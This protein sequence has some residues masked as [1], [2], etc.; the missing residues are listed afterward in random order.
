MG[1]T[2]FFENALPFVTKASRYLGN[3]INAT[4]KDLS[5]VDL[6]FALAFPDAYEVGMSH[7][8]FHILYHI[9]NSHDHIA[10][11]RVFAPWPDM[12][13]VMRQQ[14]F[15][16]STLESHIPLRAYDIIGFS[17]EYELSY[18]TILKMFS[19]SG[20][21]FL[22]HDRDESFP[23]MIAGGPSTFNPEPVADFF[24]AIVIGEGEEVICEV[25][26]TFLTW[27][28]IQAPKKELLNMLSE[29][30]GIYVPSLFEIAYDEDGTLHEI[31][32]LK[33]GYK[34]VYKRVI[35]GF[36]DVPFCISPI[37]PYM[38]IIHDRV[39]IEIARGCT[40]GCRF[41]MAGMI[42]RP[43][44]E[45]NIPKIRNLAKKIL[46]N[47]GYEELSLASLSTGDFSNIHTLLK[48][49]MED[50]RHNR[51]AVSF[52][53]L[54]VETLTR[55]LMEEIKQV[56]KTGF[57][58][59]PEAGTQRLRDVINK[60]ITDGEILKTASQI[61]SAGWNL[62]KLYFM[63]GLPTETWDDIEGIIHL[64]RKMTLIDHKKQLNVSVSTFVPKPHTPFQWEMQAPSETIQEKQ[65]FLQERIKKRNIRFKWHN[66]HLSVLEGIFSRGDRKLSDVLIKAHEA[67]AGFEA[68]TDY[69]RPEVWDQAF[70][71]CKIDKNFYLR[72]RNIDECLPW[73]HISCGI[74]TE[75]FKNELERALRVE[76]TP[77]CRTHGCA[78]CG[79]CNGEDKK[80][81]LNRENIFTEEKP[82]SL[83]DH[84]SGGPSLR[85][86]I[87]FTKTGP[88]RFLSHLELSSSLA[89]SMRRARL[90]LK[91]SNGFH[92]MP[93]II[94]Y[95]AL[96]VGMESLGHF[97]DVELT[98]RIDISELASI[99]NCYLP[100]GLKVILVKENFLKNRNLSDD[101]KKYIISFPK[102]PLYDYPDFEK[103]KNFIE[104]FNVRK[105]FIMHTTKRQESLHVDLKQLVNK[106]TLIECNTI[107]IELNRTHKKVPKLTEI[108]AHILQLGEKE[109]K[110]LRITRLGN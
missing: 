51:I 5:K 3:E 8:G 52:P 70:K 99:I 20:I 102:K 10:C 27:K 48:L 62:I 14:N 63:I 91:Y 61:F 50:H 25:C 9:L 32:P 59:A 13:S 110:A 11:E 75:F 68:W 56:R 35:S 98:H 29:I 100:E 55:N 16:L 89:R 23:L 79:V 76:T 72:K 6:K 88:A 86:R 106:I 53:S 107:E 18:A 22:S 60:G 4:R 40:H 42:Y 104:S 82:Q 43:V 49:L 94:F 37:V 105:E 67:G 33:K 39:G 87:H 95:E 41:C 80:L 77:D 97:F 58:I 7:L 83:P 109:K 1:K 57:T 93:R 15:P 34:K 78:R 26:D 31:I 96:P 28:R 47:T 44:R 108:A 38:Q 45:K 12:E 92:P 103:T 101:I 84:P 19:L 65:K 85:Y 17:L 69:F 66:G 64:I 71:A 73:S 21:P 54:R 90:P 30:E 36:S 74:H 24:D 81:E 2:D 46:L